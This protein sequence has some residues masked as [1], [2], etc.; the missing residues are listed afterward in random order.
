MERV[1][2]GHR[3]ADVAGQ[4]GCSRATVYKWLRRFRDEGPAGLADRASRPRRCPHRT[5]GGIEAR[6]L[7]ARQIHRRGPD[8]IAGE[9]GLCP[10]TVGRVLR[11]HGVTPLSSLDT[12][13]GAP[14]RRG[15]RSAVRYERQ[16][17][18]E[19]VHLDVKKLGRIPPGGGWRALGRTRRD[20]RLGGQGF[21]Y[22]H[23][24]IDDHSRL[25]YSEICPDERGPTCAAFLRRAAAFFASAGIEPMLAQPCDM[26]S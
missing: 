25:A 24:A 19:L 5:P 16:S 1:L 2:A 8:W 13:T 9:L 7:R 14:V 23:S 18:G 6:I 11:R 26:A 17:P 3:A 10:S 4:L 22:V 21:D 12:L 15:P 20:D